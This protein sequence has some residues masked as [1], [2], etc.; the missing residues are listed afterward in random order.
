VFNI[1]KK[2]VLILLNDCY[3]ISYNKDF[4]GENYMHLPICKHFDALKEKIEDSVILIH[5]EGLSKDISE[6]VQ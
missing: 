3:K 2:K 6:F 1:I 5:E 4:Q